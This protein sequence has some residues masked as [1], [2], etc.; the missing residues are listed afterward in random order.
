V[1]DLPEPPDAVYCFND[2]LALG[3][4]HALHRRG[5]RVPQEVAV[6][7]T[8]DIVE[9]SYSRPTLTTV[10]QDVSE[11]A[12]L[13]VDVLLDRIGDASAAPPREVVAGFSLKVRQSTVGGAVS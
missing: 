12:T 2:L 6:I 9:S 10:A 4:L 8:D 13:A 3:A 5:I 1:L 7:G 11:I